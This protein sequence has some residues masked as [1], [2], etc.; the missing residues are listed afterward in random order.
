MK[1]IFGAL[2]LNQLTQILLKVLFWSPSLPMGNS[3]LLAPLK[4]VR[5]PNS[6]KYNFTGTK[7]SCTDGDIKRIIGNI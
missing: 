6:K 7:I 3:H 1:K 2:P 5:I 4:L